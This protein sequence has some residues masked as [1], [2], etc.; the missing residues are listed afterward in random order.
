[1]QTNYAYI[2]ITLH[3]SL[4]SQEKT[5]EVDGS[6]KGNAVKEVQFDRLNIKNKQL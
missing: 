1:M 5:L 3:P 6:A 2:L 4:W